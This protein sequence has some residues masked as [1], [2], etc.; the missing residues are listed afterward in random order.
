MLKKAIAINPHAANAYN[1]LGGIY[2]SMN[3]N[4]EAIRCWVKA[5]EENPNL[6]EA[7]FNLALKYVLTNQ[8]EKALPLL[9]EF[10]K[11]APPKYYSQQLTKVRSVLLQLQA[12]N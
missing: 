5:L 8:K 7:M 12:E 11:K 10:E 1:A 2:S 6:F 3:K 9:Q 4:D